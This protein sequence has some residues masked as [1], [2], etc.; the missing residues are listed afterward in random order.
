MAKTNGI[1]IEKDIK[2]IPRYV[3]ID[4]RKHGDNE[5]L[6]EFLDV[7]AAKARMD[8]PTMSFDEFVHQENKRRK[9]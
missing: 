7:Q 5:L 6:E 1:T 4:L 9:L 8:E 2:G 3:R